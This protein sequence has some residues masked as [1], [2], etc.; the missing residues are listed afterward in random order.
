MD[1]SNEDLSFLDIGIGVATGTAAIGSFG[2]SE[3]KTFTAIGT[4]VNLA[5][6]FESAARDGRRIL[7]DNAT[8]SGSRQIVTEAEGPLPFDLGKPDQAVKIRYQHYVLKRLTPDRPVRVFLSHNYQDREY[9]ETQ[10]RE[11]LARRNVETW[12]AEHD[13]IPGDD[14]I[15]QIQDGLLKCDWMLVILTVP[16]A[17]SD[18]VRAEVNTALKD[19]RFKGRIVPIRVD[20]ALPYQIA[21]TFGP[22]D[23]LDV[24]ASPN[25]GQTIYEFLVQRERQL[26][27]A[28]VN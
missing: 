20:K 28:L 24:T 8:W 14:Y 12:Y 7:V 2:S 21:S 13:I 26:R 19:P 6:A 15:H 3:V 23:V 1:E 18:W 10:I 25:T 17:A 27:T 16:A 4:V 22:L 9:V 11:P 5:S